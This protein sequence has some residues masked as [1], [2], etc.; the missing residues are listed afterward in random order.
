[1]DYEERKRKLDSVKGE[2]LR[3]A[4]DFKRRIRPR[5]IPPSAI[6]AIIETVEPVVGRELGILEYI[7]NELKIATNMQGDVITVLRS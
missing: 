3:R 6:E 4:P 2:A 7:T 5:N 1:M